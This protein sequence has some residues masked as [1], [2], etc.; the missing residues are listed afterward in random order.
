MLYQIYKN[1]NRYQL[2]LAKKTG[3]TFK[4]SFSH[5]DGIDWF[6]ESYLRHA[7]LDCLQKGFVYKTRYSGGLHGG[8]NKRGI[9]GKPK[10][11]NLV[12]CPECRTEFVIT[13]DGW[14][15]RLQKTQFVSG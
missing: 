4:K 15:L 8:Y 14:K 11:G 5:L 3:F 9:G 2:F 13:Y 12:Y 10:E 6:L 7:C 1:N